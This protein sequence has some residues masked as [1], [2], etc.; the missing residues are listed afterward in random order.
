M[1]PA[2]QRKELT[3]FQKG[4]IVVLG[5]HKITQKLVTN[6]TFLGELYRDYRAR[7]LE[8]VG[9]MFEND[10]DPVVAP[11]DPARAS[12]GMMSTP[13]PAASSDAR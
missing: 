6:C 7:G 8:I 3:E 9:L 4:T 11:P 13:A 12:P 5:H 2:P 1:P 10:P